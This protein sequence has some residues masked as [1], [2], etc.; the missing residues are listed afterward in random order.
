MPMALHNRPNRMTTAALVEEA[1]CLQ[2]YLSSSRTAAQRRPSTRRLVEPDKERRTALLD[3]HERIMQEKHEPCSA[4]LAD[5]WLEWLQKVWSGADKKSSSAAPSLKVLQERLYREKETTESSEGE[6]EESAAARATNTTD[7]ILELSMEQIMSRLLPLKSGSREDD[8]GDKTAEHLAAVLLVITLLLANESPDTVQCGHLLSLLRFQ[9]ESLGAGMEPFQLDPAVLAYFGEAAAVC[10]ERWIAQKPVEERVE[11]SLTSPT[12]VAAV[13]EETTPASPVVVTQTV[14]SSSSVE[15]VPAPPVEEENIE[16]NNTGDAEPHEPTDSNVIRPDSSDSSSESDSSDSESSSSESSSDEEAPRAELFVESERSV[17][18]ETED[19][20]GNPSLLNNRE[21]TNT[22]EEGEDGDD[23]DTLR[24]A[25]AL[26]VNE[27][28]ASMAAVRVIVNQTNDET[29]EEP[30]A[31]TPVSDGPIDGTEDFPDDEVE[32][33]DVEEAQVELPALPTIPTQLPFSK[34]FATAPRGESDD[35]SAKEKDEL[36]WQAIYD[37]TNSKQFASLPR[38]HVLVH[39]MRYAEALLSSIS[40]TT[41]S[42]DD[43]DPPLPTIS[44]GMGSFLYN[45]GSVWDGEAIGRTTS[46]LSS[47]RTSA[48]LIFQLMT[49]TFVTLCQR[50]AEGGTLGAG[51]GAGAL[52]HARRAGAVT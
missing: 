42:E 10:Q 26:A 5:R 47:D 29:E 45:V 3:Y 23:Y 51:Q 11:N 18:D 50:R 8:G 17:D 49:T 52:R 28:S 22:D 4:V 16:E 25:L 15:E 31:E 19:E 35:D 24:Q 36:D 43:E 14:T 9:K 13:D 48:E 34:P 41:P 30:L 38:P 39:L 40:P 27:D 2:T 32:Q 37:P 6:K 33:E 20:T 46:S 44:G 21:N 7:R 1:F 12:A